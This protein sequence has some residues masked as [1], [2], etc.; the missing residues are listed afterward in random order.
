MGHDRFDRELGGGSHP[1][2]QPRR[3]AES[4]TVSR[5]TPRSSS[6]FR[7]A[8]PEAFLP[9][10]DVMSG[11]RSLERL[12]DIARKGFFHTITL[13]AH[14]VNACGNVI[15]IVLQVPFGD[16]Y[17]DT[18]RPGINPAIRQGFMQIQGIVP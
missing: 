4:E 12:D 14:L 7:Y 5:V 17:A 13:F 16:A 8:L 10:T 2:H 15:R 11:R 9:F 3:A 18:E 6:E 1:R